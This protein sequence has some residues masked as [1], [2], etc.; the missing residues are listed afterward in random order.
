[1]RSLSPP[2]EVWLASASRPE[3]PTPPETRERP[4]CVCVWSLWAEHKNTM[5]VR[6]RVCACVCACLQ[7]SSETKA[8]ASAG[9]AS[10]TNDPMISMR[11]PP[12]TQKQKLL[13]QGVDLQAHPPTHPPTCPGLIH[14]K[15]CVVYEFL[16]TS[17]HA[18]AHTRNSARAHTHQCTSAPVHA[19]AH[20]QARGGRGQWQGNG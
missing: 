3:R 16:D 15:W 4:V 2:F 5:C 14:R 20:A 17:M 8:L 18:S 7:S 10:L 9:E 12:S 19:H 1:M 13:R 11:D 6:M